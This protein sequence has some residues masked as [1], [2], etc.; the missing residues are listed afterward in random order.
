MTIRDNGAQGRKSRHERSQFGETAA[1][2]TRIGMAGFS[3]REQ[4]PAG[5]R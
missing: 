1:S 5:P 3:R 2:G 4:K